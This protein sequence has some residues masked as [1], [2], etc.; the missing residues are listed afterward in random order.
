MG[1]KIINSEYD[2]GAV[3]KDGTVVGAKG[4]T[5]MMQEKIN[6]L[7]SELL[8]KFQIIH[9]RVR[10]IDPNKPTILVCHDLAEDPEV[11][12]L[13]DPKNLEKFAKL[14][15]V[16]HW[17]FT[18]YNKVLGV[19]YDNSIVLRN[20]IKP[21]AK[22]QKPHDGPIRLIYHTTPHRGLNILLAA[23]QE[24]SKHYGDKIHLD[25]FSSFKIYG[26]EQR[27]EDYKEL[28]K[29]CEEHPHITYHGTKPNDEV[30]EALLKAHIFAYPSIWQETSCIAAIEAMSAGCQIVC[31]SYA[32][33]PETTAGFAYM[34]PWTSN[35]HDHANMFANVLNDAIIEQISLR[36]AGDENPSLAM[37]KLYAD[38]LYSWDNRAV[39]WEAL[40]RG[41]LDDQGRSV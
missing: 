38:S 36:E 18:T 39:E 32:A 33:L 2:R 20:A 40:L 34:Y 26:W 24:L 27:D 17:Q 31:P 10:E 15:F 16:S 19:P 4:G 21:F 1:L 35:L 11:L 8:S 37:Q 14:V 30:R 29:I 28:F 13:G 7:D 5:E 22:A 3:S 9:S 23:Y 25:V 12:H 41:I 6:S